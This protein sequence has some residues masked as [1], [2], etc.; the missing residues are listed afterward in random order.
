MLDR[1]ERLRAN[2]PADMEGRIRE[3]PEQCLVAWDAAGRLP[4]PTL[5]EI[6][7]VV[8]FAMG[9]SAIGGDL[10]RALT[11]G[12]A[13]RPITVVRDYTPPRWVGPGTLA[14]GVSYSGTTEE[15]LSAMKAA[16]KAGATPLALGTGG[17]L[18]ELV[19]A[20]GGT[21]LPVTYPAKPRAAIAHLF[22][23]LLRVLSRLGIVADRGGELTDAVPALQAARDAWGVDA[24]LAANPAKQLALDLHD[25]LPVFVAGGH[26]APVATRWKAQVNEN[27]EGWALAELLP[28]MNHNVV[29]GF[30]QPPAVTKLVE[31]VFLSSPLV[32]ERIRL[33]ERA[34][35][36]LLDHAGI[37]HQAVTT[38]GRSPLADQLQLIHLG[39]WVSYYL[40]GLR[41]VDPSRMEPIDRLK[42]I[43]AAA[44]QD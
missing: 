9:G 3:F 22:V 33:R 38:E 5:D 11:D 43:L 4:L 19:T 15:T 37:R 14:I 21:H 7:S 20:A 1:P 29:V 31:V 18:A 24:P 44:R 27:A 25:R 32:P 10:V 42:A 13:Q 2:D 12:D 30:S 23:P 16:I 34:T 8:I 41:G 28:E 40:A 35:A 6:G 39:D 17:P 26:L 36:D